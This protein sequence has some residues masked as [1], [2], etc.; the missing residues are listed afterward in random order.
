[1]Y[2][3]RESKQLAEATYMKKKMYYNM[4]TKTLKRNATNVALKASEICSKSLSSINVTLNMLLRK[5]ADVSGALEAEEW[6]RIG[7]DDDGNS[8]GE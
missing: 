5:Q 2:I 3:S 1:M 8:R 6:R 7:D 4:R